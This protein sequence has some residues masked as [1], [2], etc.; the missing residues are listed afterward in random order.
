MRASSPSRR[1]RLWPASRGCRALAALR[2]DPSRCLVVGHDGV[3]AFQDSQRAELRD[4][5]GELVERGAAARQ[6]DCGWPARATGVGR[7]QAAAVSA[8]RGR[9]SK[10]CSRASRARRARS[11]R[12]EDGAE[13]LAH[14]VFLLVDALQAAAHA[15]VQQAQGARSMPC[16]RRRRLQHGEA[17]AHGPARSWRGPR[18]CGRAARRACG[19]PVSAA[20]EGVGARR[21]ATKSAMVT[22]VSCPT[23]ETTGTEQAAMARATASVVERPQV[24]QRAAAAAPQSPGPPRRAAEVLDAAAHFLHRAFALHQRG[25]EADVQAGESGGERIWIISAMTAPRGDVTMPIRRG[26]RGRGRLRSASKSPSANSFFLS[27][28][29]ASCSAPRPCGSSIST[30]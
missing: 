9:M 4:L 13:A 11:R 19:P 28:S 29:K 3:A 12:V 22:S 6:A 30:S 23:A 20:A 18:R 2:R 5:G 1:V 15:A 14:A 27:C 24:F 7:F 8:R 10:R 26:K 25:K 16:W 21:S 17:V